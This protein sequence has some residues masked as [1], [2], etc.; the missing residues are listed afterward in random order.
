MD[1][2]DLNSGP[3]TCIASALLTAISPA[4]RKKKGKEKKS[5]ELLISVLG[6]KGSKMVQV[7]PLFLDVFLCSIFERDG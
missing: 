6:R 1:S 5:S 3:Q 2:G 7:S 4:T